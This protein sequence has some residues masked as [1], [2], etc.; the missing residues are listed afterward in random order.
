MCAFAGGS[1][2]EG[3]KV[4][5]QGR[6]GKYEI[7]TTS[8][9]TPRPKVTIRDAMCVNISPLLRQVDAKATEVRFVIN[10]EA[11]GCRTPRR[12]A[13]VEGLVRFFEEV[14]EWG[15]RMH[16]Y[17]VDEIF[18]I[19]VAHGLDVNGANDRTVFVSVMPLFMRQR[20]QGKAEEDEN[21]TGQTLV[22]VGR[23][24]GAPNMGKGNPS[25]F[26]DEQ[27]RSLGGAVFPNGVKLVTVAEANILVA[28]QH[29]QRLS[30]YLTAGVDY[31]EELVR[32]QLVARSGR[33]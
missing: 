11:K 7:M 24:A 18:P 31:I 13:E 2:Q 10:R 21:Y 6:R 29:A 30:H 8:K 32:K 16:R 27:K 15:E 25:R 3:E 19:Q 17:F 26:L 20:E 28:M 12:N 4:V 22:K 14:E 33:R 1:E 5:L 9:E 23:V